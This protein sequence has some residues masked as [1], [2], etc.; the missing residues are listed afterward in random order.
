MGVKRRA[1]A[2]T[3]EYLNRCAYDG[4]KLINSM[5][6]GGL[7]VADY[8]QKK[9]YYDKQFELSQYAINK[10]IATPKMQEMKI[11]GNLTLQDFVIGGSEDKG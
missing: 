7:S 11:E 6:N 8:R 1:R 10:I 5:V 3:A 2:D 4:A 9:D